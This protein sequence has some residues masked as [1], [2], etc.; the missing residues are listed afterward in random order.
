[1]QRALAAFLLLAACATA[2]WLFRCSSTF[3]LSCPYVL[4]LRQYFAC[5]YCLNARVWHDVRV[6][7]AAQPALGVLFS[8]A[9]VGSWEGTI[10]LAKAL[11]KA[12][13]SI[14]LK[15]VNS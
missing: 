7:V 15:G 11:C 6:C 10:C 1:M 2:V 13:L 9:E 5:D 12:A 3:R 14:S 4:S 8:G